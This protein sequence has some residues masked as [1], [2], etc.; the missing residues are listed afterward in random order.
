MASSAQVLL[1]NTPNRL[2]AALPN[3]EYARLAPEVPRRRPYERERAACECYG[4]IAREFGRLVGGGGPG[5]AGG[6]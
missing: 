6:A 1:Q 5:D 3:A 4:V 2:L